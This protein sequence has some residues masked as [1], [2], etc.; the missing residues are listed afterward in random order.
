[1]LMDSL[2]VFIMVSTLSVDVALRWGMRR[3]DHRDESVAAGVP[4]ML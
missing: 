1:M 3:I 2:L 4:G